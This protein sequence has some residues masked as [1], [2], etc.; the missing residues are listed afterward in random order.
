M[1]ISLTFANNFRLEDGLWSVE[2]PADNVGIFQLLNILRARRDGQSKIATPGAPTQY[3][4]DA[5]CQ[6]HYRRIHA[7][8]SM[9]KLQPPQLDL[10]VEIDL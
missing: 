5:L 2:M 1:I 7:S 9:P 4:I 6:A 10:D 3:E 8:N